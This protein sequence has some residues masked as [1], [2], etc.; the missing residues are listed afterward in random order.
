M[1]A[2]AKVGIAVGL[3]ASTWGLAQADKRMDAKRQV[4]PNKASW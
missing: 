3:K 2:G 1:V 4:N